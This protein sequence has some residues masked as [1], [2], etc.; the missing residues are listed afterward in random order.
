MKVFIMW[1]GERSRRI[2]TELRQFL[3]AVV[4]RPIY[5][6]STDNIEAGSVWENVVAGELETTHFGVAC[7]AKDSLQS[8][9]IHFEAGALS[10]VGENSSIV[11]YLIGLTPSDVVGP[12]TKFQSTPANKEGT[13]ALVESINN[14]LPKQDRIDKE[15]LRKSHE[16]LWPNL[17]KVI[18]ESDMPSSGVV[19]KPRTGEDLLREILIRLRGVERQIA[20]ISVTPPHSRGSVREIDEKYIEAVKKYALSKAE[21]AGW[22]RPNMHFDEE[23]IWANTLVPRELVYFVL[24]TLRDN[25]L[26]VCVNWKGESTWMASE[27][28]K[29]EQV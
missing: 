3:G 1:S 12:L 25:G 26:V 15:T 18:L 28:L 4:Q 21:D 7:L 16:A 8:L 24:N 20:D 27:S 2:A 11:P 6:V 29:R 14:A 17:E 23:E 22:R 5:F 19:S 10:K 13:Y 9:W